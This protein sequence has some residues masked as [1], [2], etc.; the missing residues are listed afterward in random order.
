M[1]CLDRAATSMSTDGNDPALARSG[2]VVRAW[3]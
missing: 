1:G 3:L 2:G